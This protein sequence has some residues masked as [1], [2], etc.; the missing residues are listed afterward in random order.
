[1]KPRSFPRLHV[2]MFQE[3]DFVQV[4]LLKMWDTLSLSSCYGPMFCCV[5]SLSVPDCSP[6]L[7]EFPDTQSA[8]L[9][10]FSISLSTCTRNTPSMQKSLRIVVSIQYEKHKKPRRRGVCILCGQS[11]Q[12][13]PTIFFL[14]T[15][16]L[17]HLCAVLSWAFLLRWHVQM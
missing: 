6:M 2:S 16:Y 9:I 8:V 15:R 17:G 11:S 7:T 13:S 14:S 4:E 12:T 3:Q 10:S 5:V 1:M